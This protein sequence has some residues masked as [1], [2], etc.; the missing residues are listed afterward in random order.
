MGVD[1]GMQG[2]VGNIEVGGVGEAM[3]VE[4]CG[5]G[6]ADAGGTGREGRKR[7]VGGWL[8]WVWMLARGEHVGAAGY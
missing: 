8:G 5:L 6:A 7:G 4:G 3:S 1:L 2:W